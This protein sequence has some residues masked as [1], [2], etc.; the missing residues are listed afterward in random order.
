MK[1]KDK[2]GIRAATSDKGK[3]G[4]QFTHSI[5]IQYDYVIWDK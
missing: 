1:K 3:Q 2:M 5:Y 4:I